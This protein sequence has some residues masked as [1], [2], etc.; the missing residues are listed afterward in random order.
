MAAKFFNSFEIIGVVKFCVLRYNSLVGTVN[1]LIQIHVR[2]LHYMKINF[3]EK[4]VIYPLIYSNT[5]LLLPK[6]KEKFYWRRGSHMHL[7]LFLSGSSLESSIRYLKVEL[8]IKF[9]EKL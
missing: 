1:D 6:S 2:L 7:T 9:G 3:I 5:I 4:G 8:G